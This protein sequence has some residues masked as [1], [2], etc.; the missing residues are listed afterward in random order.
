MYEIQEWTEKQQNEFLEAHL[1]AHPKQ[2]VL[3]KGISVVDFFD[4]QKKAEAVKEDCEFDDTLMKEMV[5]F[6]AHHITSLH[7][8]LNIRAK[9]REM[10]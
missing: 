4:T 6:I 2:F 10:L 3:I 9:I 5:E 7:S 8:A 1:E